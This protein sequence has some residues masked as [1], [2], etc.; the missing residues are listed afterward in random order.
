MPGSSN[1]SVCQTIYCAKNGG[2]EACQYQGMQRALGCVTQELATT[3]RCGHNLQAGGECGNTSQSLRGC[4]AQLR[5]GD[6][7]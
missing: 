3:Y 4:V 7:R 2:T 1:T 6:G 5:S